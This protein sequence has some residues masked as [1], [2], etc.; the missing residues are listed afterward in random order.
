MKKHRKEL[1]TLKNPPIVEAVIDIQM[2]EEGLPIEKL[3]NTTK[4]FNKR[5]LIKNEITILKNHFEK[6]RFSKTHHGVHGIIHK[7]ANNK[8]LTQFRLDGFSYNSLNDYPG[9]DRFF[10][11]AMFA[12]KEYVKK[13]KTRKILRL[14]LRFIN[15]IKIPKSDELSL[16]FKTGLNLP[17][18]DTT[19]GNIKLFQYRYFSEF[20]ESNCNSIVN[21][22]QQPISTTDDKKNFILDIDVAM[23]E[24]PDELDNDAILA[25]HFKKMRSI[26]NPIFQAHLT[27]KLIETYK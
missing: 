24:L 20:P 9:W 4:A 21:F 16:F 5:F 26:K 6:G 19:I 18:H 8:E 27:D 11:S 22:I 12:W 14:G 15:L 7:N 2:E 23:K 17:L 3:Q 10:E 13:R 25:E 1:K